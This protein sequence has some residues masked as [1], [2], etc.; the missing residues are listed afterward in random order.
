MDTANGNAWR[1]TEEAVLAR[2]KA[3]ILMLQETKLHSIDKL[4]SATLASRAVGW[5]PTLIAA[6]PAG[7]NFSS[8]GVGILARKGTGIR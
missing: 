2:S 7:G 5:N 8:G 3:D 1:S 4:A 6:H